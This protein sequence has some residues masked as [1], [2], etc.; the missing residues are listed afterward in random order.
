MSASSR[1]ESGASS[2]P[3]S[4]HLLFFHYTKR[5]EKNESMMVTSFVMAIA[6]LSAAC[7]CPRVWRV[8]G[9]PDEGQRTKKK[10]RTLSF[11]PRRIGGAIISIRYSTL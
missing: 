6:L 2:S 11:F 7:L 4:L 5:A 3:Q 8:K 9:R 10:G 1:S